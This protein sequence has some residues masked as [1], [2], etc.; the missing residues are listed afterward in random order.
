MFS[1]HIPLLV[2]G[3]LD[4]LKRAYE[5]EYFTAHFIGVGAS[6]VRCNTDWNKWYIC[7]FAIAN[8]HLDFAFRRGQTWVRLGKLHYNFHEIHIAAYL[9]FFFNVFLSK[10]FFFHIFMILNHW[11]IFVFLNLK[12][13]YEIMEKEGEKLNASCSKRE[14]KQINY[15]DPD[16]SGD[17]SDADS[18]D[19]V[20]FI[21]YDCS[22]ESESDDEDLPPR[23]N[24]RNQHS[25]KGK[26]W[27]YFSN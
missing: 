23:K 24:I 9:F 17:F 6:F 19:C 14:K 18:D 26:I 5:L 11:F 20:E 21:S 7:I 13:S 27:Y 1:C 16:S 2:S 22:I 15:Y 3:A 25:K 4:Q 12:G 10:Q 8:A